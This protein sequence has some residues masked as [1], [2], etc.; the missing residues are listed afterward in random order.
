MKDFGPMSLREIPE[1]PKNRAPWNSQVQSGGSLG[2]GCWMRKGRGKQV[3]R[4]VRGLHDRVSVAA[5][6]LP[7]NQPA[8]VPGLAGAG[9]E[10]QV[11]P[12]PLWAGPEELPPHSKASGIRPKLNENVETPFYFSFSSYKLLH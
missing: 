6:C 4:G 11:W 5:A 3:G 12:W 1:V 10:F 2:S 9:T 8:A 7:P